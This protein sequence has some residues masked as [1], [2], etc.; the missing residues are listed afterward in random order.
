MKIQKRNNQFKIRVSDEFL[1]L[2]KLMCD[3]KNKSQSDIINIA[4]SEYS[5]RSMY[6][7]TKNAKLIEDVK[8][9]GNT[10]KPRNLKLDQYH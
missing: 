2:L 9:V 7:F 3:Q 5:L 4:L 8:E 6:E 10:R 1:K